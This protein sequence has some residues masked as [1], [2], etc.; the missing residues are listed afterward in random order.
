M[1]RFEYLTVY[2]SS[3][4]QYQASDGSW[5]KLDELGQQGWELVSVVNEV[6][7]LVAFFKRP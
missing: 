7:N 3:T 5:Q 2:V 4:G 1:Q 6:N